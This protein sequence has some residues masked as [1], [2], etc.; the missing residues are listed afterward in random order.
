MPRNAWEALVPQAF[1]RARV[2]AF[3]IAR[4]N[5]EKARY[6]QKTVLLADRNTVRT[7][8]TVMAL[9][10]AKCRN[11]KPR[12]RPYKL[13]DGGGLYLFVPVSGSRLWRFDYR[14]HGKRQTMPLGGYPEMTLAEA[15][16]AHTGARKQLGD[17]LNP[18]EERRVAKRIRSVAR[19]TTFGLIADELLEKLEREKKAPVTIWKRRWLLK[20][21]A[22]DL[23]DRPIAAITPAEVLAVLRTVEARGHLET[24]RRLR[25]AIGQ[26]MRLAVATNRAQMDPTPA[27]RGAIAAPK[28]THRAAIVDKVG[29]G[30]LMVAVVG[31]DRPTVRLAMM[32]MAYC[33]PR[34]GECRL[35]RWDEIDF[36]DRIWTIPAT[37]TKMRR[38]HK[39]PLSRQ[40]LEAF[41]ELY[42]LTGALGALC[43][44]GQRGKDRPISEN[45]VC[46]ALRT[47]GFGKDEMSAHGFRALASS[48]LHERSDFSSTSIERALGHQDAN[49][50]RR[51][52]ARGEHWDDRVQ[53]MQ[54]WAD[55]LDQL[56]GATIS[57]HS[58]ISAGAVPASR[59]S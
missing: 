19:A 23:A 25:A 52:Y 29:A 42:G 5:A 45:T 36:E 18:M 9:S 50:V 46:A 6:R 7:G 8:D 4:K 43:F 38:E 10:D 28:T 15:R 48:L 12:S 20:D 39:I 53:L 11:A 24:A 2:A 14:F 27:L 21:L 37:R 57:S 58:S 31:Y 30:K 22:V 51:A 35:A 54:W 16:E 1:W 49:A 13:S 34:P 3:G 44:P 41:R 26:V 40:A 59:I 55:Y 17:D 47:M 32:I 33:V 56:S